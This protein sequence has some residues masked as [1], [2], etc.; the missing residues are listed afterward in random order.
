MEKSIPHK[1]KLMT[2]DISA[3]IVL[4]KT[5]INEITNVLEKLYKSPL[6]IKV[7]LIDN[8]PVDLLRDLFKNQI[9]VEYIFTGE[10]L[11]F[12]RGHN[13]AINRSKVNSQF[14]LILNADIDF[15]MPILEKIFIYMKEHSEIGL[16]GPK[17]LNLDGTVQYTRKLLPTP[18][19]LIVR[20]FIPLKAIN[21]Y[22]DDRYELRSFNNDKIVEM[23][24]LIGCFLFINTKVFDKID[25]FDE[26]FFMYME[27]I[28]LSRR[29]HSHYKT[30]YYPE[31]YIYH[32]H[33]RESYQNYNLMLQ[34]IKSS[35][36]YFNKWGWVFDNK[37]K[38]INK[39]VL[40][41]LS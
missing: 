24:F 11:G 23:P 21:K 7:F 38:N 31:V 36:R 2:F 1:L 37:R 16:L 28:D 32:S 10:N 15:E 8:S 22:I 20:R 3:S 4:Y 33:E 6:N 35:I 12:G 13:I 30:I 29:I 17:V 5:D 39:R 25:G 41:Q 9:E 27:D 18:I 14:H 40:E 34:H 19:D 26:Q